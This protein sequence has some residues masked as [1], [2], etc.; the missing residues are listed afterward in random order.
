MNLTLTREEIDDI[1]Y[2]VYSEYESKKEQ[3]IQER[4]CNNR[5]QTAILKIKTNF[6][7]KI[8]KNNE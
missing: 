1:I 2:E 4:I 3:T 8:L 6:Y 7:I 5:I